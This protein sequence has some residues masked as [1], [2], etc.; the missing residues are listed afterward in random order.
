MKGKVEIP[1][2]FAGVVYTDMD[3]CG[4][5]KAELLRELAAAG[6]SIDWAKAMA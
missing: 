2:D 4:A 6:Y 5:W 3:E 1:S